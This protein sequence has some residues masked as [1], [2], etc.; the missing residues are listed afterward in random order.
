MEEEKKKKFAILT[1][2]SAGRS[3][4]RVKGPVPTCKTGRGLKTHITGPPPPHWPWGGG[5][6]VEGVSQKEFSGG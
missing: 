5:R 1:A 6:G 4:L 2:C 3:E